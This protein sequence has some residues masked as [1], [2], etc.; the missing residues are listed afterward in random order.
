MDELVAV[1]DGSLLPLHPQMLQWECD[2]NGP[3]VPENFG[4]VVEVTSGWRT[5]D[6]MDE[7]EELAAAMTARR[8]DCAPF[9]PMKMLVEAPE[10]YRK[11]AGNILQMGS[12]VDNLGEKHLCVF[13]NI[14]EENEDKACKLRVF[15]SETVR[16]ETFLRTSADI[17]CTL[18][19]SPFAAVTMIHMTYR[20][21][22]LFAGKEGDVVEAV[23]ALALLTADAEPPT[24]Q[25]INLQNKYCCIPMI[26]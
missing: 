11:L 25:V 17:G 12:V 21:H 1:G 23:A 20:H 18:L 4:A 22:K 9:V 14:F 5:A 15:C 7:F 6:F 3:V 24:C 2:N 10:H 8:E 19:R 13:T 16:D 26:Q